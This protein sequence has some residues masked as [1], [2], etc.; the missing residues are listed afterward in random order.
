MYVMSSDLEEAK[1]N[2]KHVQGNLKQYGRAFDG[3]FNDFN[4]D[5]GDLISE[6]ESED[7][8]WSPT[9]QLHVIMTIRHPC[10][11]PIRKGLESI[12]QHVRSTNATKR[13]YAPHQP[14]V[15]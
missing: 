1:N 14:L 10:P 7:D 12:R 2:E 8:I 9:G 4:S 5:K 6:N 11:P 15:I 3:I 13:P